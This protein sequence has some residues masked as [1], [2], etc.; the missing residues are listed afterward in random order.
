M[1]RPA[2]SCVELGV[3]LVAVAAP[4]LHQ[5]GRRVRVAVAAGGGGGNWRRLCA[6]LEF[7]GVVQRHRRKLLVVGRLPSNIHQFHVLF[8]SACFTCWLFVLSAPQSGSVFKDLCENCG[9]MA[10]QRNVHLIIRV[11][12]YK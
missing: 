2:Y 6:E 3:D 8:I 9:K 1:T 7:D 4:Q 5:P 12:A 10:S 11:K